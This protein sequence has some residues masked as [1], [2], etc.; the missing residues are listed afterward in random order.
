MQRHELVDGRIVAGDDA[1]EAPLAAQHALEQP[2]VRVTRHAV[3]LVIRRH[4]CADARALD[5]LLERRE[6]LLAQRALGDRR[7]ADVRAAFGLAV[8][9]HVLQRR[10]HLVR[11]ERRPVPCRPRP[12]RRRAR[13]RG[14]GPRRKFPRCDPSA[15]RARRRRPATST[16][17]TPRA[18]IS[19]AAICIDAAGQVR[20]PRACHRDRLRK[21]RRVERDVAVQGFF[22]EQHGDAEPRLLDGETLDG[23]DQRNRVAGIAAAQL[24]RRHRAFRIRRPCELTDAVRIALLRLRGVELQVR[25]EYFGLLDPDR[26]QLRDFLLEGHA[27]EQ[28]ID[29]RVDRSRRVPVQRRACCLRR[30]RCPLRRDAGRRD[31]QRQYDRTERS[32]GAPRAFPHEHGIELSGRRVAWARMCVARVIGWYR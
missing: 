18:R 28:V 25:V 3:D 21:H 10:E 20:V 19:R 12:R 27:R 8:A 31:E 30:G 13:R 11:P 32:R 5:H 26:H 16:R 17:C 24:T 14:T 1:L 9:G 2:V 4:H 23:V 6:E 15:G 29:T 7:R 22:V